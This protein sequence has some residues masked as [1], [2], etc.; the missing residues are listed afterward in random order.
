MFER[1]LVIKPGYDRRA[2]GNGQ[3]CVDMIWYLKG[4]KGII[5][6][7][8]YTGWYASIIPQPGTDW[9]LMH[10]K[11]EDWMKVLPADLGYHSPVPMYDD[12][13]TMDCTLLPGGKCYYDGSGLNANRIFSILV[14]Q[15]GEAVW[16][17]LEEEYRLR[18]EEVAA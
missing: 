16:L 5:Q 15:G 1:E 7:V 3:H 8:L 17:E 10:V 14:H 4:E 13:G 18:F 11:Q 9:T 12:Q 6:F 2:E